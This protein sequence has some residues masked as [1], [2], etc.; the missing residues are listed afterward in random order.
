MTILVALLS[1][2]FI[3]C[4]ASF[5]CAHSS[6][7]RSNASCSYFEQRN[8]KG[9]GINLV[10]RSLASFSPLKVFRNWATRVEIADRFLTK[11]TELECE[12]QIYLRFLSFFSLSFKET[13]KK[14]RWISPIHDIRK[15]FDS[16]RSLIL[17]SF[18]CCYLDLTRIPSNLQSVY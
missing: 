5:C 13:V 9:N 6:L 3:M 1:F 17:A 15:Y 11:F 12:R 2:C 7:T 10:T 18:C 14:A 8:G 16:F 4:R